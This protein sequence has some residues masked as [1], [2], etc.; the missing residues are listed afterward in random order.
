M[1]CLSHVC[2]TGISVE[3]DNPAPEILQNFDYD[4]IVATNMITIV[5]VSAMLMAAVLHAGIHVF[6]TKRQDSAMMVQLER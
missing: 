1:N 3:L 4:Q 6:C 2:K 5:V